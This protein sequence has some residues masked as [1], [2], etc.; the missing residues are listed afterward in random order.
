MDRAHNLIL[1]L[2]LQ[3]GF[4]YLMFYLLFLFYIFYILFKV[5]LKNKK[6]SLILF[7]LISLISYNVALL[8]SF[9]VTET[10]I[11]F[12]LILAFIFL[13]LNKNNNK[14]I[15]SF[16]KLYYIIVFLIFILIYFS[17]VNSINAIKADYYFRLARQSFSKKNYVEM[18]NNYF[19]VF[20]YNNK[21]VIYKWFFANDTLFSMTEI[22]SNEALVYISSL[23]DTKKLNKNFDEKYAEATIYKVL[24]KNVNERY[25]EK[26]GKLFK[27]LT[28]ES[29]LLPD[30]YKSWGDVYY[31][32]GDYEKAT[33][34]Y[35]IA[36]NLLP[37]LDNK[38]LNREHKG[39]IIKF[40]IEVYRMMA[41]CYDK[42]KEKEE[43]LSKYLE[44]IRLD[45]YQIY[46]YRKIADIYYAQGDIKTTINLN[47]RAYML[48]DDNFGWPLAIAMLYDELGD[49]EESFK[50]VEKAINLSPGNKE[51]EMFINKLNK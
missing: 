47:K 36:I 5:I 31:L 8:S 40:Q 4:F 21:P 18:F 19:E 29:S 22:Q 6:Q 10:D 42:L 1:D 11:L 9:S 39:D 51:V 49:D 24:G 13:S 15:L 16:S 12:Y 3:G 48:D 35:N 37:N 50:Y 34:I 38:Y 46:I 28:S 2:L 41:T 45:P 26:S 14:I 20:H 17:I 44:I 30:L 7:L 27:E 43:S 25:Y 23:I 33:I 32:S